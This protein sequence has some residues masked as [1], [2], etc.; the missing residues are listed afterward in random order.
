[1]FPD[2]AATFKS[3]AEEDAR[4]RLFAGTQYP[5]DLT[6]GMEL[7]ARVGAAVV[8]Y[9]K[10]DGSDAQFTG[11][12]PVTPGVWS[13]TN[14]VTPLAGSWRPW[15]APSGDELRLNPPPAFGSAEANAQ[16]MDVK[17][18]TRTNATNHSAWFWQPSFIAPWLDSLNREIFEHRWD[19][20]PP[21]AAHAYALETIAQHDATIGCWANKYAYLELRPS[22]ADSSIVPLFANPGHPGF[23]SGH[24]CASAGAAAVL[25]YLFPPDSDTFVAQASDAGLSTFYA[26]IHTHFDVDGGLTLGQTVG[27][28]VVQRATED[29]AQ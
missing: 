4:S 8:A 5:S 27:R 25:G 9:A 21:R 3:L 18:Q 16:Y 23:P 14:P 26:N 19:T 10:A 17:N 29:G 28:K 6:A 12:F 13:N 2:S 24:A 20:N 1:L 15:I 7:G 11:S 22:M